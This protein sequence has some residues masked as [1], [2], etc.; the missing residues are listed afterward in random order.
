MSTYTSSKPEGKET[1]DPMSESASL[2]SVHLALPASME[3]A[4]NLTTSVP[5]Y[6]VLVAAAVFREN[7]S[8][9]SISPKRP[10]VLLWASPPKRKDATAISSRSAKLP[11]WCSLPVVSTPRPRSTSTTPV[12]ATPALIENAAS[13]SSTP[14]LVARL[15]E[16]VTRLRTA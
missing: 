10:S 2:S 8:Q 11:S 14:L 15:L 3:G 12:H 16:F 6:A 13:T 4:S 5:P 1:S 9:E 7:V